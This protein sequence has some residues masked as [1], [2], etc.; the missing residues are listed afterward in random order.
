M[1]ALAFLHREAAQRLSSGD[2]RSPW[3]AGGAWRLN[4]RAERRLQLRAGDAERTVAVT[5]EEEGYGVACVPGTGIAS[6]SVIVLAAA[7]GEDRLAFDIGGVRREASVVWHRSAAHL[8]FAG[9]HHEVSLLDPLAPPGA[10]T[11]EEGGLMAPM[12]GRVIAVAVRPG[13]RVLKGAPLLVLEAMKMEYTVAAPAAGTVKAVHFAVG[14]SVAAGMA[15][16]E[17]EPDAHE[18]A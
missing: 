9:E 4:G 5:H 15:L 13:D 18:G 16:V 8:F 14:D 2:V 1:A 10:G 3:R 17:F 12:P 6:C 7:D 11:G